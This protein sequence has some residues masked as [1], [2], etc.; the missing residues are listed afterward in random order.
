MQISISTCLIGCN[1]QYRE[2]VLVYDVPAR[3]A[4]RIIDQISLTSLLDPPLQKLY[5]IAAFWW[6]RCSPTQRDTKWSTAENASRSIPSIWAAS[7]G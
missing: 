4:Q 2:H 3:C 5:V 1:K 7:A 6:R